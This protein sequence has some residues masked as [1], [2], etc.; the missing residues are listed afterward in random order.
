MGVGSSCLFGGRFSKAQNEEIANAS[1]NGDLE[2][3]V[4]MVV[5]G[6]DYANCA[7]PWGGPGRTLDTRPAF[8]M[9]IALA[10]QC[11][12]TTVKSLWNQQVT[13]DAVIEAIE[14]VGEKCGPGD[15]FIFYY[16]G[17]G[18][19]IVDDDG[20]EEEGKDEAMCFLG[21]DGQP[22]PRD[23]VWM[24]DD[25]LAETI[26]GAVPP[27]AKILVLADCCHS[28]SIL[29]VTRP[30][31]NGFSAISIT[32]CT[33]EQTSAGSGKGGMF[34]RAMTA[35]I[36]SLQDEEESGYMVSNL[37]NRTLEEYNKRKLPSHSQN[38]SIHGCGIYP[39]EMVFPLQPT[40]PYISPAN[41]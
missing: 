41:M 11:N 38:I 33:D 14:E 10:K 1:G 27:E 40:E 3:E 37:Y 39:Q 18:D 31:W 28:G 26:T 2:G 20:D 23:E 8:E 5:C 19:R 9:M 21:P 6:I 7:P 12:A 34:S 25:D 16:T 30:C 32:G 4:H 24:R 13:K 15:H 29:D 36:Q 17:H 22:E 35:A